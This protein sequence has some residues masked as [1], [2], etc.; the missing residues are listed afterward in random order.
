MRISCLG[1][2]HRKV[3]VIQSSYHLAFFLASVAWRIGTSTSFMAGFVIGF[4]VFGVVNRAVGS[5]VGI[6]VAIL[7]PV[8][9][10]CPPAVWV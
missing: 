8:I 10:T 9:W 7:T 4:L 2:L 6:I 5:L 1:T 3:V